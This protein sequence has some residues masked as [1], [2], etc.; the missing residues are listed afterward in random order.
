MSKNHPEIYLREWRID[1]GMK[2]VEMAEAIDLEVPTVSRYETGQA[3]ITLTRLKEFAEILNVPVY[4]LVFRPPNS[5]KPLSHALSVLPK[6]KLE[7]IEKMI[8]GLL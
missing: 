6:D 2:L 3:P 8:Q 4:D 1:R 5:P 7:I